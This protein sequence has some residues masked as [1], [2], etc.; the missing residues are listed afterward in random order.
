MR[1]KEQTSDAL[2]QFHKL[3]FFSST[4][5]ES[6]GFEGNTRGLHRIGHGLGMHGQVHV[7]KGCH[8][9]TAASSE[10]GGRVTKMERMEWDRSNDG[11]VGILDGRGGKRGGKAQCS[12][13]DSLN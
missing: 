7:I 6:Q 5:T 10:C 13:R 8:R 1:I 2:S 4:L 12:E 3:P 9:K 11:G